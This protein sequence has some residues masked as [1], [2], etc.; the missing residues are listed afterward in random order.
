MSNQSQ[1]AALLLPAAGAALKIGKRT[2]PTP[3]PGQVLVR[4]KAIALNPA[5][6]I[7]QK[8]GFLVGDSGWPTVLGQ[9]GAGEIAVVGE[10]VTGWKVGDKVFYQSYYVPDRGS[11]QE[12]TIADAARIARV[13][14]TLSY[15][16]IATVPLTLATAAIAM[17]KPNSDKMLQFG[18]NV[19]GAGLTPPWVVGGR[20]KYAGQPA[21]VMSGAGSVGQFGARC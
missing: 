8:T 7:M 21:L 18:H 19:G 14:K 9:D 4:N 10:E 5:D 13:P 17:Y 3:G 1:H 20:E 16:E 11:F 15:E 6:W 12:L 2:T